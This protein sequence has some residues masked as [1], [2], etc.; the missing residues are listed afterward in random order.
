MTRSHSTTD[1]IA[2]SSLGG[3]TIQVRYIGVSGQEILV[4][5]TAPEARAALAGVV[6]CS[7]LHADFT[8]HYRTEV[9]LGRTLA[10]H[11]FAT[12]RFHYRGTGHSK[13]DPAALTM[14]SMVGDAR[15]A[16]DYLTDET[17]LDRIAFLGSRLG[18]CVA[19]AV[20]ASAP[21][22]PLVLWEPVIAASRYLREAERATLV[23]DLAQHGNHPDVRVGGQL[24][25]S[26]SVDV[27]G[28]PVT[29]A[30]IDSFS[31]SLPDLLGDRARPILLLQV[32]KSTHLRP[33]YAGCAQGWTS[34]GF[35]V[36]TDILRG[37]VSWWFRGAGFGRDDTDRVASEGSEKVVTWLLD[38]GRQTGWSKAAA[39][40]IW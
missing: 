6:I 35:D 12:L 34:Q 25:A 17:S 33:E 39:G 22:S 13:G 20:T 18:G 2:R 21:G 1:R 15:K 27:H 37:E 7:P 31:V 26:D 4:C 30:L 8:K 16:I 14:S 23:V 36:T 11:G 10:R 5:L 40:G 38:R 19:A 24:D 29:R 3:S 32:G 28:Y 9:E